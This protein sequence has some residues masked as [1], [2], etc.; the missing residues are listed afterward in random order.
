[1]VTIRHIAVTC[2]V[3]IVGLIGTQASAAAQTYGM[4]APAGTPQAIV[5]KLN[6][7]FNSALGDPGVRRDLQGLGFIPKVM[8]PQQFAA[9]LQDDLAKWPPIIAAAGISAE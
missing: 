7:A 5:R 2:G 3:A 1:M 6:Q 4:L 8:T 9:F